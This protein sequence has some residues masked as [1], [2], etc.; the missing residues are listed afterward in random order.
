MI[1]SDNLIEDNQCPKISVNPFS[2]LNFKNIPKKLNI[3][4][5]VEEDL[6]AK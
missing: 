3:F 5:H 2:S 4:E 6:E 1:Y